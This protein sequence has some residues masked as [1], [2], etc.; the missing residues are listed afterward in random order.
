[1]FWAVQGMAAELATGALMMAKIKA[2]GRNVSMLVVQNEAVFTK[3][4][5]GRITFSC[6]QGM[7]VD[8][9]LNVAI[10]SEE[11]G[12]VWLSAIGTDESGDQVSAFKFKWSVKL[13]P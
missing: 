12:M 2:S 1:M 11:A 7:E 8:Q 5:V 9:T 13:K 6:Q 4:A 3:K 10:A